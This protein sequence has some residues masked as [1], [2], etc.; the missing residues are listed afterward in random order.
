MQ[1][2]FTASD[3]FYPPSIF[4][5]QHM[6]KHKHE[7]EQERTRNVLFLPASSR[8]HSKLEPISSVSCESGLFCHLGLDTFW[9]WL[10][11]NHLNGK[12]LW[13]DCVS[14]ETVLATSLTASQLHHCLLL[15]FA[16]QLVCHLCLSANGSTT[17]ENWEKKQKIGAIT[18]VDCYELFSNKLTVSFV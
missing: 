6:F 16:Y 15:I 17:F 5:D 10:T 14:V 1:R 2:Y 3:A 18:V 11:I 8:S 4:Y 9:S 7:E 12:C 13:F